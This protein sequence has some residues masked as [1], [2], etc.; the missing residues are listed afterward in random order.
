MYL[1]Y[2]QKN[3]NILKINMYNSFY[4]YGTKILWAGSQFKLYVILEY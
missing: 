4:I 3:F 1:L 2:L